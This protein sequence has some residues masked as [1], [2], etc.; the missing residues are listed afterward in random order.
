MKI[1]KTVYLSAIDYENFI[2]DMLADRDFIE[3]SHTLCSQGEIWTCIFVCRKKSREG[4][5]VIPQN[6]CYVG[7]AAFYYL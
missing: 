1:V 7:W 2:F 4:I 3:D 6:R 5:L